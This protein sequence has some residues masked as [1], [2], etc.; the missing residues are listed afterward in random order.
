MLSR[1]LGGA[2]VLFTWNFLATL[3]CV[4]GVPFLHSK[5]PSPTFPTLLTT[6]FGIGVCLPVGVYTIHDTIKT[7]IAWRVRE[8]SKTI[9]EDRRNIPRGPWKAG[10]IPNNNLGGYSFPAL[11][12]LKYFL[13]S[14]CPILRIILCVCFVP[15]LSF[16]Y[17]CHPTNSR[18][19]PRE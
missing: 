17:S 3:L 7:K 14:V 12:P 2:C 5:V 18:Y 10:K 1:T 6:P 8:Y 9:L 13:I 19:E 4:F 15:R 16:E 11:N